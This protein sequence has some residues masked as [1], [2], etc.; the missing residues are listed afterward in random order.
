MIN[1]IEGHPNRYRCLI[2]HAGVFDLRSMYG[3]TEELWFPEWEFQGTPWSNRAQYDRWSPSTLVQ[4][5]KTPCLVVHGQ[6]DFRV[7]VTQGFQL[8]TS[9][10]RQ[11]V[12]SRFLY[13]PDE[14]HFVAKPRNAELWWRVVH[15]WLDAYL[16]EQ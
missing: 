2:S 5:F 16:A 9:L 6:L 8:F 7:P 15:E 4:N 3:A 14:G 12:D 13:F 10:Q 1:W 11:G